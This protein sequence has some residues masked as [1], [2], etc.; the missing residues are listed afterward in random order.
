VKVNMCGDIHGYTAGLLDIK[1][2]MLE[3][4]EKKSHCDEMLPCPMLLSWARPFF[5]RA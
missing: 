3:V 1:I 5:R 4:F 2:P